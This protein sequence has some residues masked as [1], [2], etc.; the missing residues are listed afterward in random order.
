MR[1]AFVGVFVTCTPVPMLTV[2]LPVGELAYPLLAGWGCTFDV[3]ALL[4]PPPQAATANELNA[5]RGM[6]YLQLNG[7]IRD[8]CCSFDC[9]VGGRWWCT[10]DDVS[11]TGHLTLVAAA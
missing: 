9:C 4:P 10:R 6:A 5:T 7:L 2:V 3:S 8:I 11:T 1:N